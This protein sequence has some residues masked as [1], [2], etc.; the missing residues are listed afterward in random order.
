MRIIPAHAGQTFLSPIR[1]PSYADHPRACGANQP[2]QMLRGSG[3]GSSPRMRGKRGVFLHR[4]RI[5]RII[6]AHAG[7]TSTGSSSSSRSPDHPRACGANRCCRSPWASNDGSSPRMRG[8]PTHHRSHIIHNRIIPAHAG[9]TRFLPYWPWLW[10]DHPRACGANIRYSMSGIGRDGSSPRMRGKLLNV[11]T[12]VWNE[13]IIPA[14]AGQTATTTKRRPLKTDHPRACGANLPLLA[15]VGTGDGSSPRMRGKLF[16]ACFFVKFCRIIPA[17]AGQ[18]SSEVN[19]TTSW[20][21]HPRACGA[22]VQADVGRKRFHGSSPRMRG[23]HHAFLRHDLL[24]RIIPA[25]A[26][27]TP[28]RS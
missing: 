6:P 3:A 28:V 4:L 1:E 25:H 11:K 7:Q 16:H 20:T 12:Q 2:S 19:T 15:R 14:H 27:Q 22:N 18:T 5:V 17:H 10:P 26:G 8:K 24:G 23:K 21:D 13:R 9:Q